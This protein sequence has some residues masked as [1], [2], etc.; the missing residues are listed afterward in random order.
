VLHGMQQSLLKHKPIIIFEFSANRMIALY[1][2]SKKP[3]EL[4]NFLQNIG[5]SL[6]TIKGDII[7]DAEKFTDRQKVLG[8]YIE[9]IATFP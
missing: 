3:V 2:D 1:K 4:L 8:S 7:N 9:I 5:Y 6:V